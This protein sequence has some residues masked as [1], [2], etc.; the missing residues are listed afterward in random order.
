MARAR[1]APLTLPPHLEKML[2]E[3]IAGDPTASRVFLAESL[4]AEETGKGTSTKDMTETGVWSTRDVRAATAE[5][6]RDE[7]DTFV[8]A[9]VAFIERWNSCARSARSDRDVELPRHPRSRIAA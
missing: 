5:R 7:T 2:P 4:K 9:A 8:S 3:V 1:T 6:G